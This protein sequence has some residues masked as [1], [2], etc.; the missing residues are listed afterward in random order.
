MLLDKK[1]KENES[2]KERFYD[3]IE[4][5]ACPGGCVNGGGQLKPLTLNKSGEKKN[6]GNITSEEVAAFT[7]RRE[8][9]SAAKEAKWGDK[10]WTKKVE[11]AYWHDL[12]TPPPSPSL[13]TGHASEADATF[14]TCSSS[15]QALERADKLACRVLADLCKPQG[16]LDARF[17]WNATMDDRA[18]EIRRSLFRTQY[19]A[20]E[21]DVVGLQVKW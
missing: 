3:Y 16:D 8:D 1:A 11:N 15:H 4:V 17:C 18:E 20:V 5:M 19:R 13:D 12:P 14:D 9:E 10:E 6:D 7:V 2:E 21:S